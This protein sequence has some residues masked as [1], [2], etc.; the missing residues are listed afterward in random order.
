MSLP[1]SSVFASSPFHRVQMGKLPLP[2][3]MAS[4]TSHFKRENGLYRDLLNMQGNVVLTMKDQNQRRLKGKPFTM[5]RL[6][7]RRLSLSIFS[8]VKAFS[9][10]ISW[11]IPSSHSYSFYHWCPG[12]VNSNTHAESN[13]LAG[14]S[15]PAH[16][17]CTTTPPSSS[18]GG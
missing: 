15:I 8:T 2:Y 6:K 7:E 5:R 17:H 10:Y 11:A 13:T 3:Q 16:A 9:P 18:E 12:L 4:D 14:S 1:S